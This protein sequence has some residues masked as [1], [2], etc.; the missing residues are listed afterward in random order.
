MIKR[1]L[2][3][4]IALVAFGIAQV[5]LFGPYD[6]HNDAC[7]VQTLT[8]SVTSVTSKNIYW[9][10]SFGYD[11]VASLWGEMKMATTDTITALTFEAKLIG[12]SSSITAGSV[13]YD[14]TDWHTITANTGD[15]LP[16]ADSLSNGNLHFFSVDLAGQDWWKKSRG[17]IIKISATGLG[18]SEELELASWID[19]AIRKNYY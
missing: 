10:P 3:A 8:A 7:E 14:S 1:T 9:S 12:P 6:G 4:V 11:G 13:V 15:Y 16:T 18:G 5:P 17:I 19:Y 2:W